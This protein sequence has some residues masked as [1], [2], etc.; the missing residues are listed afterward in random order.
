VTKELSIYLDVMRTFSAFLIVFAHFSFTRFTSE[1]LNY[2]HQFGQTAVIIFFVLSG[3]VITYV[4]DIKEKTFK[5]YFI[6]RFARLYSVV[7]IALIVVFFL[8]S[9]G[10]N[11]N[12]LMYEG[13]YRDSNFLVRFIVNILFLQQLWFFNISYLSDGPLWS[14]G[15]EFWYYILFGV[16]M[17]LEGK[18]K[19]VFII[20]ISLIIGPK[21]LLLLPIW[22]CGVWIYYFHQN[23]L[24]SQNI[25]RI[26]FIL[27]PVL[28]LYFFTYYS[29]INTF[30]YSILGENM[31]EKLG[32]SKEFITDYITGFFTGL[33]ILSM[34][35]I[36]LNILNKILFRGER[37]I[38]FFA[39]SSF[40]IYLFHFPLFLFFAALFNHNPN[41]V[42]DIVVLFIVTI[43]SCIII[44]QYTEN[45]KYVYK[46]YITI[47]WTN[48]ERRIQ[49]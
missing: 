26:I 29:E 25:S 24:L 28:F 14:L 6:S 48:I 22:L 8:D 10:Q 40:S 38:R 21:I 44:A 30:I 32:F 4:V 18:K 46:K 15:Y 11:F 20:L 42:I 7:L 5:N 33:H 9:I 34:K 47:I 43:L 13:Y 27:T 3:Y 1:N 36:N 45:K 31:I 41:S 17:F 39:N 2:F 12:G 23:R 37:M 19:Y 35:Y 16:V 49:K